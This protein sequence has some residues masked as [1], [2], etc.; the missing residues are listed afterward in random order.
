MQ[1]TV[2]MV[3]L[4]PLLLL[5]FLVSAPAAIV[6]SITSGNTP[7]D[8]AASTQSTSN[9][10]VDPSVIMN[11]NRSL[12]AL[13]AF[14][15]AISRDPTNFLA[16]WNTSMSP[17]Y[18]NWPGVRCS[19]GTHDVIALLLDSNNLTGTLPL[20]LKGLSHLSYLNVSNNN[21]HGPIPPELGELFYLTH[22]DLSSNQLLGS[23]PSTLANCTHLQYID[24]R[25][26]LLSGKFPSFLTSLN[27]LVYL[28]L[29]G[30]TFPGGDLP[31][32]IGRIS[33]LQFL[34]LYESSLA[35]SL[36][37]SITNCTNL[38][39]L[40]LGGNALT[41]PLPLDWS[42]LAS[43]I[44]TISLD[45]N[46]FTGSIPSSLGNCST[47]TQLD[48]ATNSLTGDLPESLGKLAMLQ[49]LDVSN[50]SISG[51]IPRSL[52]NCSRLV[53]LWLAHNALTG[54]IPA[55]IGQLKQLGG[56]SF[57]QNTRL[58]GAIPDTIGDCALLQR[59]DIGLTEVGGPLPMSIYNLSNLQ[60]ISLTSSGFLGRLSENVRNL[61]ALTSLVLDGNA[62]HG[63]IPAGLGELRELMGLEL[64]HNQFGG[65]IPQ[66]W[67]GIAI[68]VIDLSFNLLTGDIPAPLGQ[69]QYLNN[70]YLQ[71]NHLSGDIPHVFGSLPRLQNLDLSHNY[72]LTGQIPPSLSVSE[73]LDL[74][75]NNLTG[76]IPPS[77][78]S[79]QMV[80]T[81]KLAGNHF[82][83]EI[84]GS[85]AGCWGLQVLDL[86]VNN[87]EGEIPSAL[88]QLRVLQYI[89]LS[90]N[91][92]SGALPPSLGDLQNLVSLNVSYN[93]L[94]GMIPSDGVFK[95]S[96][97]A[98]FQ[99]NP[100][101]C[102]YPL[103]SS[104]ISH[105]D[106]SRSRT[107]LIV[108]VCTVGGGAVLILVCMC[109]WWRWCSSARKEFVLD[110]IDKEGPLER[111][112][113][114][115][116]WTAPELRA[117][118]NG[119]D[120]ANVIGSSGL[121]VCFKGSVV[122]AQGSQQLVAIKRLNTGSDNGR[123]ARKSLVQELKTLC[124]IRHRNLVKTLG[125]CMDEGEVALVM[126]FMVNGNLDEHLHGGSKSLCWEE[127]LSIAADVAE[128][129][130]YLH[131]EYTQPI[132]HCDLKPGN[133]LL[134]ADMVAKISDFGIA[135][136]L[137]C[138]QTEDLFS[139]SNFRGTFGYAA[140]ECAAGSRI[141][142]KA[143]VYSY[144]VLLIE[145][146]TGVK[147][148]SPQLQERGISLHTWA[149]G[150]LESTHI[151]ECSVDTAVQVAIKNDPSRLHQLEELLQLGAQC[152]KATA[153]ERPNIK[154]VRETLRLCLA[155]GTALV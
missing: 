115:R 39:L 80:T 89:D 88:G 133:I 126:E 13:L 8:A 14:K 92:L 113:E 155:P 125:Y 55:D 112:L 19:D 118:T 73:S 87:L 11:S 72:M 104:C 15:Q 56:V 75:F 10:S 102:G 51:P 110:E 116:K 34:Q 122:A 135:R 79:M 96:S 84:P 21:F 138:N 108:S 29:S 61:T 141:S 67:Q 70:L 143:D 43:S 148:T 130:V 18:C 83:G 64:Q 7:E 106:H 60:F 24:L 107:I 58:S 57:R 23:I 146:V 2:L 78:G 91:K 6:S 17:N 129:L 71:H 93:A 101:L 153:K 1:P 150:L 119:F 4:T 144:G 26:N 114:L 20:Q 124:Q 37:P 82:S 140:P 117:A 25:I 139:T 33:N 145:I 50:N 132:I 48:L 81:I 120:S 97:A 142:T 152:T 68:C 94:Q 127:R 121:S 16:F 128:G 46:M 149:R 42:N 74:S 27:R 154:D 65:S 49:S 109:S 90:H 32:D 5:S 38:V 137:N 131:H 22:L 100:G 63:K 76:I 105:S 95:T 31:P 12:L 3:Y 44:Q 35:G 99:G 77:M 45:I 103:S 41:G 69:L 66:L 86:S 9:I 47:L 111:K 36:P 151:I 40:D 54:H 147:P 98:A 30:N 136:L 123:E 62:F 85:L 52:V 53:S 59:L 134:G 28:D